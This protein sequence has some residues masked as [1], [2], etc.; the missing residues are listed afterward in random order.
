[1]RNFYGSL[2]EKD[3]CRYAAIEAEKFG[4]GGITYICGVLRCDS[5]RVR[6]GTEE[7]K[8]PLPEK[9]ERIRRPGGGRKSVLSTAVGLDDAFSAVLKNHTAGSP[10]DEAIKW[11][12]LKRGEISGRLKEY[13]FPVSVTV[14]DQ[15]LEKHNF[16]SRRAFRVEAGKKNIPDRDEQFKNIERLKEEYRSEGN[17]VMSMD[18][19]KKG[20]PATR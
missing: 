1:M 4:H 15:L 16:R 12:N 3:R 8:Q 6:R 5:D 10:V 9:E 19:K 17:P 14:V 18:V 2:S 11:T 13:G 20:S 7:L